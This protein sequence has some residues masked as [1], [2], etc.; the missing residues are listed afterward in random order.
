MTVC[1][2]TLHQT[3]VA[4]RFTCDIPTGILFH[5]ARPCCDINDKLRANMTEKLEWLA[6]AFLFP[7]FFSI[8]AV[9]CLSSYLFFT[10][11]YDSVRES[12]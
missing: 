12:V 3:R 10:S 8:P 7:L 1:V 6:C 11:Q 5:L 9:V 4:F 2:E